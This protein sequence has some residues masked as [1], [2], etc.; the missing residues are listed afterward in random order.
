MK[1]EDIVLARLF[2]GELIIG[3]KSKDIEEGKVT[4][5]E[6]RTIAMVP[7]MSGSVQVALRPICAPFTCP[8]LTKQYAV[9][10]SQ[11]MFILSSDE[12]EKELV[13]G[14]ISEVTGIAVASGADAIAVS[15]TK[16]S[17]SKEEI[18]KLWT[19]S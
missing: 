15:S 11:V 7:T 17:M 13:N 19:P 6:P 18:K 5:D 1:T 2:S 8:R 4:L 10:E 12:I 16:D 9:P 3:Q 14:Y